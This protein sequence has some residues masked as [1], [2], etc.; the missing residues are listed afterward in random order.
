MESCQI[1]LY[2]ACLCVVFA[3]TQRITVGAAFLKPGSF[4]EATFLERKTKQYI[5]PVTPSRPSGRTLGWIQACLLS[6]VRLRVTLVLL[7][8]PG[9]AVLVTS[10]ASGDT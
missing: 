5:A 1:T 4:K 10:T 8:V 2:Q 9:T 6:T 7:R 3:L